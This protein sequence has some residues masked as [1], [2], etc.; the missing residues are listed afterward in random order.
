MCA[1]T[2]C[3]PWC[4]WLE[5]LSHCHYGNVNKLSDNTALGNG[6]APELFTF[7]YLDKMHTLACG[8][9]KVSPTV[10]HVGDTLELSHMYITGTSNLSVKSDALSS[11]QS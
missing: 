4:V 11:H 2:T 1:W 10:A 8:I 7:V 6:S 5:H 3:T 9:S